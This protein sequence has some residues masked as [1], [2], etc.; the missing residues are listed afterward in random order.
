M[1]TPQQSHPATHRDDSSRGASFAP[2]SPEDLHSLLP[3]YAVVHM[4]GMGEHGAV[5]KARR[6]S[7][8]QVVAIK[9]LKAE[10]SSGEQAAGAPRPVA[11]SLHQQLQHPHI[12]TVYEAGEAT[13][14]TGEESHDIRY[15]V[16]E[17]VGGDVLLQCIRSQKLG[18]KEII[19]AVTQACMALDYAHRQGIV[20]RDLRPPD[21]MLNPEGQVKV[22]GLGL[23][24]AYARQLGVKADT[25]YLAP[26]A[27]GGDGDHRADIYALGIIL[28]EALTGEVPA[29]PFQPVSELAGADPRLDGIINKAIQRDPGSRYQSITELWTALDQI[30]APPKATPQPGRGT[31]T[32]AATALLNHRQLP[33]PSPQAAKTGFG[34]VLLLTAGFVSVG[35]VAL[36]ALR[37]DGASD[38]GETGAPSGGSATHG[39]THDEPDY[40]PDTGGEDPA[41][42]RHA[43]VD[44]PAPGEGDAQPTPPDD[45]PTE[46]PAEL[47]EGDKPADTSGE[48]GGDGEIAA[49]CKR[50]QSLYDMKVGTPSLDKLSK[51][52]ARYL[53]A[54][55]REK[56]RITST[57][58]LDGVLAFDRE[59]EAFK[60]GQKP[61]GL[62][63]LDGDTPEALQKIRRIYEGQLDAI[64]GDHSDALQL[65]SKQ[66]FDELKR[67][68]I[69]HTKGKQIEKAI[70]VRKFREQS[71]DGTPVI[72]IPEPLTFVGASGALR[73]PSSPP[74]VTKKE[75]PTRRTGAKDSTY[76]NFFERTSGKLSLPRR[77]LPDLAKMRRGRLLAWNRDREIPLGA[78][79]G[80]ADIVKVGC[81]NGGWLALDAKGKVYFG[82]RPGHPSH[83]FLPVTELKEPVADFVPGGTGDD[84]VA[85]SPAGVLSLAAFPERN[86][87]IQASVRKGSTTAVHKSGKVSGAGPCYDAPESV[88]PT[89]SVT[90]MLKVAQLDTH[91]YGID[92]KGKLH[93]WGDAKKGA[94]PKTLR[95]RFANR[96]VVDLATQ[97]GS[98]LA[99]ALTDDGK[100]WMWDNPETEAAPPEELKNTRVRAVRCGAGV[101]AV[102]KANGMW[103]AWGNDHAGTVTKIN[104]LGQNIID[105][106]IGPAEIFWIQP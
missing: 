38:G 76:T 8:D 24:T 18:H 70:A 105:I 3:D 34:K 52:T 42:P 43:E 2:L 61:G 49:L 67:I 51:T 37:G 6:L 65:I 75:Q 29:G 16:M 32:N 13:L 99:L 41:P 62:P 26:E 46:P 14:G 97:E 71:V 54:L 40:F 86:D 1:S 102:Q 85:I 98:N 45:A 100:I 23:A 64:S 21:I 57:G 15:A 47:V 44:P 88:Q 19:A 60:D 96:K 79:K 84:I 4:L 17:F 106:A 20:H 94:I 83:P 36:A 104:S 48:D 58:N 25:A 90:A 5:Y 10:G 56:E 28:Y 9:V 93:C 55:K 11:L 30:I 77:A 27:E 72:E 63:G 82:K 80:S 73:V 22:V 7:D 69:K 66:F 81:S 103:F 33:A 31:P 101:T 87:V 95:R 74:A 92:S 89:S 12:A 59:I 91:C 68:E 50:Y 39:T 78:A 53:E 35:F